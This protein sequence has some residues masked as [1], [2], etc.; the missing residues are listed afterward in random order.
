MCHHRDIALQRLP[1]SNLSLSLYFNCPTKPT[2]TETAPCLLR[3][4]PAEQPEKLQHSTSL[5]SVPYGKPQMVGWSCP[6]TQQRLPRKSADTLIHTSSSQFTTSLSYSESKS[7][8]MGTSSLMYQ[9]SRTQCAPHSPP[10]SFLLRGGAMT[11]HLATGN[12]TLFLIWTS[13]PLKIFAI[14]SALA[15][16]PRWSIIFIDRMSEQ[17]NE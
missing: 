16:R 6:D 12:R 1:T 4:L 17:I 13:F 14:F 10:H 5:A 3:T 7:L 9:E 8:Q 11:S 15:P 2:P